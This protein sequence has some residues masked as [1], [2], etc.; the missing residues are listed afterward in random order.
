MNFQCVIFNENCWGGTR[1]RGGGLADGV[2]SED[3]SQHMCHMPQ[4]ARQFHVFEKHY[5]IFY[6]KVCN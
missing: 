4:F 1:G 5:V 2:A 6:V 3:C